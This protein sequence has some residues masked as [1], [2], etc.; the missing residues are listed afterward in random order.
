TA[1]GDGIAC[2]RIPDVGSPEAFAPWDWPPPG[3][4]RPEWI[5]VAAA[6]L[7]ASPHNTQ[8]WRFVVSP[9]Q[10]QLWRDPDRSVGALD[11]LARE[12]H[13]GLGCAVENLVRAAGAH[14]RAAEVSWLPDPSAPDHVANVALTPADPVSDPLADAIPCRHTDRDSYS[15]DPIPGLAADLAELASGS[16]DVHLTVIEDEARRSAFAVGTLSATESIVADAE[17]WSDSH[18]WYRATG[19]EVDRHRDGLTLAATG[20]GWLTRAFGNAS[21]NVSA[22]SAGEYWIRGTEAR[23][24]SGGAYVLLGTT[25]RDDRAQQL[26]CGRVFQRLALWATAQGLSVQP[27]NQM[28]EQQDRDQGLGR[29]VT[30][31]DRLAALVDPPAEQGVQMALRIGWPRGSAPFASPRR[32]V[33]WVT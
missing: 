4:D 1:C 28:P 29:G 18:E 5:A 6:L 8:P 32:P 30:W 11:G 26:A 23:Q 14:G 21:P 27:L 13:L 10:V 3:E 12:A 22:E 17:M 25:A 2:A 31:R 7:A 33:A 19:E 15:D 9:A 16:D 20:L 24:L